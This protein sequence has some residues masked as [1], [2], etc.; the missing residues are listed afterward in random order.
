MNKG[1]IRGGKQLTGLR[2]LAC[3]GFLYKPRE[4]TSF[5]VLSL[6]ISIIHEESTEKLLTSSHV[7]R[8]QYYPSHFTALILRLFSRAEAE[9]TIIS[10]KTSG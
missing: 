4:V 8:G 9:V 5:T 1:R 10:L 2:S 7:L 3:T 6:H